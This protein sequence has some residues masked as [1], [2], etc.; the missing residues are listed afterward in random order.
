MV[1]TVDVAFVNSIMAALYDRDADKLRNYGTAFFQ[2]KSRLISLMQSVETLSSKLAVA[3]DE[4]ALIQN[5]V[6]KL[7]DN[8][9][10]LCNQLQALLRDA[11]RDRQ[12]NLQIISDIYD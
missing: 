1:Q 11:R 12:K 9:E 4:I 5:K 6:A 7:N 10:R 3:N 2:S 8:K